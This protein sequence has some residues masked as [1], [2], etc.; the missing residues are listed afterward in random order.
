MDKIGKS[1]IARLIFLVLIIALCASYAVYFA[2]TLSDHSSGLLE[3]FHTFSNIDYKKSSVHF[4]MCLFGTGIDAVVIY[5]LA[6]VSLVVLA[7]ESVISLVPII[8]LR[9]IGLRKKTKVSQKEYSISKWIHIGAFVIAV[10]TGLVLTEFKGIV[11]IVLF[12]LVWA[13]FLL[14]YSSGLKSKRRKPTEPASTDNRVDP[15]EL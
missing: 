14:I 8:L 6:I 11:W 15:S 2:V 1:G 9:I 13:L 7:A 5:V 3:S 10:L 12:N 4:L